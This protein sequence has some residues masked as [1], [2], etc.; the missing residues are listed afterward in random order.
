METPWGSSQTQQQLDEDVFLLTT[1]EAGGLL[2]RREKAL[3]DLSEK[4][5]TIG[6][7]WH[8]FFAFAQDDSMMVVFYEHPEWY[9]WVEEE[10]TVQFADESLRR[11]HPEYFTS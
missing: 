9:P 6:I 4:A 7:P 8:D 11:H 1:A 3:R 10:L 5:R 2:I